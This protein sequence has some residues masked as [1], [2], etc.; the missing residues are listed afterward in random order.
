MSRV[1]KS[2]VAVPAG[3]N[4]TVLQND[5]AVEGPGGRLE[6]RIPDG[7]SVEYDSSSRFLTVRRANDSR[8]CKALHGLIRALLANMVT[9]VVKPFE[10]KLEILG[11]G[12]QAALKE[13][14]IVLTVG[15]ANAISLDVPV[16]LKC[17]LAD[18]THITV[19]GADNE[20]VG[21]FAAN[22]RRV[23]PPEPYKGKGIRYAGEQVR[24]KAGKAFGAK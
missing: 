23:R 17:V 24:R 1:G 12:Y 5:V 6:R 11:V 18:P 21:Q 15:Y 9:G 22:I 3:V 4:I 16:G 14:K 7:V 20:T 8:D 2:P 19:S 13:N 10:R